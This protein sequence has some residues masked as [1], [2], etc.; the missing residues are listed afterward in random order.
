MHNALVDAML[1]SRMHI[2]A[3][4]RVKTE[5]VI[6]E[7]SRGKKVP[8]KIGM[9]PVQRDGLEYEFD[10]VADLTLDN[11]MLVSG[12]TR[13]SDLKGGIFK[14]PGADVAKILAS[15][16]ST[17]AEPAAP[18]VD[19]IDA[20]VND[21]D[22]KRLFD[23]LGA[24]EAKRRATCEKHRD[25]GTLLAVLEARLKEAEAAHGPSAPKNGAPKSGS[26]QQP[27]TA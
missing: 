18:P 14:R 25:R 22:V 9:A 6:E 26:P 24:P 2:I 3:T 1:R 4:M 5:Y 19:P 16:L 21:P 12:K 13:C 8:R 23:K 20:L 17:G 15:W 10:V 27:P 7:D 11:E